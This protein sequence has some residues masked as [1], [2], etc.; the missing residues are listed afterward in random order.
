MVNEI[1]VPG[2][3]SLVL[4]ICLGKTLCSSYSCGFFTG[5][6]PT[7]ATS[8]PPVTEPITSNQKSAEFDFSSGRK[9]VPLYI[10]YWNNFDAT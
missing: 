5:P 6:G 9:Y 10:Q 7:V 4:D 1:Q 3:S 2:S 8:P